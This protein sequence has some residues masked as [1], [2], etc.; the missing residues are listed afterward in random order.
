[1]KKF[2]NIDRKK[3]ISIFLGIMFI[4]ISTISYGH[5][6]EKKEADLIVRTINVKEAAADYPLRLRGIAEE[7]H[8]DYPKQIGLIG[9]QELKREK[10]GD[11]LYGKSY[12]NDAKCLAAELTSLYRQNAEAR[13]SERHWLQRLQESLGIIVDDKWRILDEKSW[14]IGNN[15]TLLEVFLEHK[16]KGYKLRFY[17][18][19]FSSNKPI[20]WYQKLWYGYTS[21]QDQGEKR[22]SAQASKVIQI[23]RERAKPGEL[24]PIVVG[25]FNS[26]RNFVTGEV[27]ISV[28]K[29]E[30]FFWRPLDK[31]QKFCSASIVLDNIYI[32]KKESFPN[33]KGYFQLIK[34]HRISMR[35]KPIFVDGH[36][37]DELTDHNPEGFSFDI[38]I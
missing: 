37:I 20:K 9:M 32:G 22:R 30:G 34:W 16:T 12:D 31:F 5:G 36:K 3:I 33:S 28:Q 8:H 13:I 24:P 17:N 7:F 23:V 1:M 19:H 6:Q 21:S 27:E 15:R 11:C 14:S 2:E 29:M 18:T 35:K 25:D 10:M 38:H 4:I 26:G